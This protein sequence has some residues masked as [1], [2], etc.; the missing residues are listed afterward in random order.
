[1]GGA[2]GEEQDQGEAHDDRRLSRGRGGGQADSPFPGESL[3]GISSP[4]TKKGAERRP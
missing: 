1:V 3:G 4:G 2:D